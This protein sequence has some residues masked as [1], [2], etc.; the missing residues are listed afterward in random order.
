VGKVSLSFTSLSLIVFHSQV[1]DISKLIC[2]LNYSN[3]NGSDN[4]VYIEMLRWQ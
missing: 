1:D 4:L 2:Q 3:Q